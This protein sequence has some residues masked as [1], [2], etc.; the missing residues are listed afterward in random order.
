[1]FLLNK[2]VKW[3]IAA[4]GAAAA[5]AVAAENLAAPEITEYKICSD[6]INKELDGYKIVHISDYHCACIP[7]LARMIKDIK[8]DMI[9]STGDMVN[10]WGGIERAV[11]LTRRL[12]EIAPLY[13]VTGNHD[14][15]RDEHRQIEEMCVRGEGKFLH[16]ESV[17]IQRGEAQFML[18][19][20]DDP[21]VM[22]EGA[23][24]RRIKDRLEKTESYDGFH[25]LLFHRA[26][27][28]ELFE[29]CGFDLI[30]AGHMHGGQ[31][32]IPEIGGVISPKK[33]L[34]GERTLFPAYTGGR[35]SIGKTELIVNR[36]LGNPTIV[37]R[38]CN[39]PEIVVIE[40][41]SGR[42]G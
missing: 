8:A 13:M 41:K 4:A 21:I 3:I 6:K 25:I 38:V 33:S 31:V 34:S 16:N 7:K 22:E 40:L 36:G 19:G 12:A 5:G 23:I 42:E 11:N 17:R 10:R 26:N 39:R 2:A 24:K 15:E 9:V 35:Y 18:S 30:L 14:A 29:D 27:L 1:M 37:P 20:I 32:R 28:A